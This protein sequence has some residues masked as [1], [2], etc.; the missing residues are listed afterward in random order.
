[1]VMYVSPAF[2]GLDGSTDYS[3]S[4]SKNAKQGEYPEGW[5]RGT[6]VMGIELRCVRGTTP[7]ISSGRQCCLRGKDGHQFTRAKKTECASFKA[8]PG[9]KRSWGTWDLNPSHCELDNMWIHTQHLLPEEFENKGRVE[10]FCCQE[11]DTMS[12]S[13]LMTKSIKLK[14]A[15][16]RVLAFPYVFFYSQN[17]LSPVSPPACYQDCPCH[18][19]EP[20]LGAKHVSEPPRPGLAPS[21]LA[22]TMVA[23]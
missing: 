12:F 23:K 4:T 19:T 10:F 22:L 15:I 7:R 3:P 16:F 5:R 6:S 2:L 20:A 11:S 1:M 13:S 14:A 21:V 8:S 9:W 18:M 17:S